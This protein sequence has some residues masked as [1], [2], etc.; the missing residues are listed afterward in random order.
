MLFIK[1]L[2]WT[3]LKKTELSSKNINTLKCCQTIIFSNSFTH[4]V[5]EILYL[6]YAFPYQLQHSN[7]QQENPF[8][9]F[10]ST[11]PSYKHLYVSSCKCFASTRTHNRSKFSPC[12]CPCVFTFHW[13]SV[14]VKGYKLYD[15]YSQEF[16]FFLR[17]PF[18]EHFV[19]FNFSS[20][21]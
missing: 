8:E 13:I 1:K 6:D 3:L 20:Q 14:C 17:Y 9:Q 2:V 5:L 16:I 10:C 4:K 21:W 19:F 11:K 18:S 12:A 7:L 15:L